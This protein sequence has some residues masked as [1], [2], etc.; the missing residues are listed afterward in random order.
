MHWQLKLIQFRSSK[1]E[2]DFSCEGEQGGC[3]HQYRL[4]GELLERSCAEKDL[5]VLV[6]NRLAM[7]QQ[8]AL[9]AK[10]SGILE[11]IKMSVT[12]CSREMILPLHSPLMR[13]HLDYCVQFWAPQFKKDRDRLKGVQQKATVM[14]IKGLE[15]H[16]CEEW[17]SNIS[18]FS[19]GKRRLRCD[20][21]NVYKYLKGDGRQMDGARLFL[22]ACSD[23]T[24]S[25]G[26]R[27]EHRKFHASMRKA[28]LQ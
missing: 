21:I 17:L 10:A 4:G 9:V 12:S 13:P 24:R 6:N 7:S 25:N 23:R 27:L 11:S 22:A 2:V 5:S 20:V 15:H 8:W 18:L 28:S 1:A 3:V 26:L 19:L 14:M 16:Q